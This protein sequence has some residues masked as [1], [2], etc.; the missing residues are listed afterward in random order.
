MS[1]YSFTASDS[2]SFSHTDAK[3]MASKVATDLRR[4][5]R[6]YGHPSDLQIAE[7]EAE[8]IALLKAGY[9]GTLTVGFKRNGQW[10]EPTLRYTAR[11]LAGMSANDDDPG[12]IKTDAD[13][14]GAS[15]YNYLTFSSKW[16]NEPQQVKEAFQKNLSFT[17]VDAVEPTVNGHL[18]EDKT[19]S[20]AGV[21]LY[22]ASVRSF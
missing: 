21:A 6:F 14:S 20:R 4:M 8:A 11:D 7:Y 16:S 10:V 13:I 5:Q 22:R 9:F 17:R 1:S 2:E 15:F 3:H 12:K 18:V 19:Y